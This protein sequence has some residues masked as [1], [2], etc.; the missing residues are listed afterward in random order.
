MVESKNVCNHFIY[1]FNILS[2]YSRKT[3]FREKWGKPIF[4]TWFF[5][6]G[7]RWVFS[8]K[9]NS[10]GKIYFLIPHTF[11]LMNHHDKTN[12]WARSFDFQLLKVN[13][14]LNTWSGHMQAEYTIRLLVNEGGLFYYFYYNHFRENWGKPVFHTCFSRCWL[15]GWLHKNTLKQYMC[16]FPL[17]TSFVSVDFI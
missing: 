7:N 14:D 13:S 5:L 15:L 17:S 9:I 16:N 3:Q 10:R 1:N 8:S 2:R 6:P 11:V 4:H 12:D